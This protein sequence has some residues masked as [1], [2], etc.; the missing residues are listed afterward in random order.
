MADTAEVAHSE[1]AASVVVS[2]GLEA[3]WAADSEEVDQQLAGS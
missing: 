1:A 2:A 3:V